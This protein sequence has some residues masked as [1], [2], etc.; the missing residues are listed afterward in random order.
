[1]FGSML[2]E[3]KNFFNKNITNRETNFDMIDCKCS[4]AAEVGLQYY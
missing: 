2:A 1:M 3:G 4:F